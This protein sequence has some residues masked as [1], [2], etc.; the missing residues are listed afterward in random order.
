M[1]SEHF[2]Q[3]GKLQLWL[4]YSFNAKSCDLAQIHYNFMCLC[5][6]KRNLCNI[7]IM[8]ELL[9]KCSDKVGV[10]HLFT[11]QCCVVFLFCFLL[12]F[13][14]QLLLLVEQELLTLPE[15]VRFLMGFVLLDLKFLRFTD[16]DYMLPST[17]TSSCVMGSMLPVY[18]NWPLFVIHSVFLNVYLIILS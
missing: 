13:T 11:C 18:P 8:E 15:H 7:L 5:L 12:V 3:V 10:R 1:I 4:T 14:T 17:S 16:F 2:I 6:P 9:Q